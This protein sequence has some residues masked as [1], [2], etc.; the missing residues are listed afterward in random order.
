MELPRKRFPHFCVLESWPF[1]GKRNSDHAKSRSN[2][3][4]IGQYLPL[5]I[6]CTN[7]TGSVYLHLFDWSR[8]ERVINLKSG[9]HNPDDAPLRA[10]L[11]F[12]GQY[13]P[14]S[15]YLP[16]L[17]CLHQ[18]ILADRPAEQ[19]NHWTTHMLCPTVPTRQL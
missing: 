7:Q 18:T 5:S 11:S 14:R 13:L 12:F 19:Q 10:N 16:T 4:F 15:T 8:Q 3:S 17:K 9:S 1:T 2:L 6:Y